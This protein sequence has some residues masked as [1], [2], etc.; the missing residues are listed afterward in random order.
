LIVKIQELRAKILP[1]VA[2]PFPLPIIVDNFIVLL[3]ISLYLPVDSVGKPVEN[4]TL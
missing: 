2:F 4:T 1:H 3:W